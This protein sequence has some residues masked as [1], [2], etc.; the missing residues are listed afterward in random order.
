MGNRLLAGIAWLAEFVRK[1]AV[2]VE[3]PPSRTAAGLAVFL[4]CSHF[5]RVTAPTTSFTAGPV[6]IPHQLS[7]TVTAP[8]F[9][10]SALPLAAVVALFPMNRLNVRL[11]VPEL[12]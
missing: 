5:V 8:P 9:L 2:R 7:S 11:T 3:T 6:L 1:L 10:K 12:A 4:S